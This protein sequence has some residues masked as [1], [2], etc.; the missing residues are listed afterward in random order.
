M[1]A[2]IKHKEAPLLETVE[3]KVA[4][5]SINATISSL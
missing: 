4:F 5:P 3:T 1:R 2:T